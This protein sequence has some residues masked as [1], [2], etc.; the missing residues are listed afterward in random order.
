MN[1]KLKK[2]LDIYLSENTDNKTIKVFPLPCGV[3]KSE[4][5][6][7]LISDALNNCYGLIVITDEVE[8]LNSYIVAQDEQLTE[9]IERNRHRISI[10][11][12]ETIADEIGQLYKKPIVLM[13]TQRYFDLSINE[14]KQ[15]TANRKKMVF[16][17]RPYIFTTHKITIEKLNNVDSAL[18]DGLDDTVSQSIKE[19]LINNWNIINTKLQ[20]ELKKNEIL[21]TNYK[22]EI[23]FNS[24]IIEKELITDFF[25]TA[26]KYKPH[27]KKYNADIVKTIEATKQLMTEG[28]IVSQKI[29]C[30]GSNNPYANYF[31]VLINNISKLLQIEATVYVLDGTADIAPEYD[32][33]CIK[34]FDCSKF[35]P[36]LQNLTI[37][38]VKVNTSKKRFTE[39]K[40]TANNLIKDI[41]E[42]I[43]SQPQNIDTIF[44]Y[45]TIVD[46]FNDD[47]KNVNWFGNIKGSNQYR[48]V[49]H[50]CQVGLN[51]FPDLIYL[52]Y[53]NEIGRFNDID[54]DLIN[55]IY[56][57]RTINNLCCRLIL[58]DI[59][60]NLYRCKIRNRD[61][62]EMCTYTLICNMEEYET[63]L[64]MIMKR[65][66]EFGATINNIETPPHFI[67]SKAKARKSKH[68][69]STQRFEKWYK[70]QPKGR[71]FKRADIM[72]EC[73]IN[74]SQ[75]KELKRT[76]IL[77]N[78]KTDKQGVYIIG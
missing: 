16:D 40:E 25:T 28:I 74:E 18:K 2:F 41:I 42:Y 3:G 68:E 58:S 32:L 26:E 29:K 11:S 75:F 44:T 5:I 67:L 77:E 8:R 48:D 59:E 69:T 6:K 39:N 17:E 63:L 64:N 23:Y 70:R 7:Y 22:R 54:K 30:K 35:K 52:L 10:L 65:Y 76:N 50:I 56:D 36:N 21:N 43:K 9:Y 60:Q 38:V 73:K 46:K 45:K 71:K 61:N 62:T 53:A 13:S 14:I 72:K 37:N 55:R 4:Y 27:L 51:R 49:C 78:F 47:F 31:M 66:K 24:S 34:M 33:N 15:F 12:S 57:K 1:N 19:K 20:E